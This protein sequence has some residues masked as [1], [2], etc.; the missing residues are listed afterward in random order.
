MSRIGKLPISIPAGV[1]VT[2][3]DDNKVTI[4]VTNNNN[5]GEGE[6]ATTLS[7][8]GYAVDCHESVL[9]LHF[10]AYLNFICHNSLEF[11][12]TVT[13]C[14]SNFLHSAMIEVTIAVEYN[15]CYAGLKSLLSSQFA[16][17]GSLL[18]LGTCLHAERRG[19]D[20]SGTCHI[21][22]YLNIYLL[23]TSEDRHTGTLCCTRNLIANSVL[24]LDS[25]F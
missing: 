25:S 1:T 8:F 9:Q 12:S 20:Q 2:V 13:C 5:S 23:V 6:R 18:L 17:L 19:T 11:K 4:F 15:C 22:N 14:I 21:I 24:N 10:A 3:G 7:N 16:D